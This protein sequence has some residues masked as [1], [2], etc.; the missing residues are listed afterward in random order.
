M[1]FHHVRD[2]RLYSG[3]S[4]CD[5]WLH[6]PDA[7]AW[8]P[9]SRGYHSSTP[10][11]KGRNDSKKALVPKPG[12]WITGQSKKAKKRFKRQQEALAA[13]APKAVPGNPAS[14]QRA[15]DIMRSDR[16]QSQREYQFVMD[17]LRMQREPTPS[18]RKGGSSLPVTATLGC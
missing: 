1:S 3:F 9:Q 12:Y 13:K 4:T 7:V 5:V 15:L 17:N 11:E 8:V 16:A 6:C 2:C 14:L 10:V 18:P